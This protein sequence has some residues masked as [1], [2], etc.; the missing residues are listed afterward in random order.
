MEWNRNGR[1]EVNA[2]DGSYEDFFTGQRRYSLTDLEKSLV[3][4]SMVTKWRAA[5]PEKVGTKEDCVRV[6]IGK[7][8]SVLRG[9]EDEEGLT[10][11]VPT[12]LL[13]FKKT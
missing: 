11:G 4:A 5:N 7:V 6:T 10:T 9:T 12:T 1:V 8:R 2:D 3:T 13:M